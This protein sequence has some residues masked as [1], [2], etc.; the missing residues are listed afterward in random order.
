MGKGRIVPAGG[1]L[2]FAFD[3]RPEQ[4]YIIMRN[5]RVLSVGGGA[6]DL[7]GL[8]AGPERVAKA[9]RTIQIEIDPQEHLRLDNVLS[10]IRGPVSVQVLN[11]QS[12]PPETG[13]VV[14][15]KLKV[16]ADPPVTEPHGHG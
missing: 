2:R 5:V 13:G 9:Y 10:H 7:G 3:G 14:D 1:E 8:S 4:S 12:A 6:P 15:D 11:R 16:L